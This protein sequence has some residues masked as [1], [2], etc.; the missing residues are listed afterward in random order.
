MS[1]WF[2]PHAEVIGYHLQC[3]FD[4]GV[5]ESNTATSHPLSGG[6]DAARAFDV[7]MRSLGYAAAHAH[8]GEAPNAFRVYEEG[9]CLNWR[10]TVAD[11]FGRVC[12]D[13][14]VV[15]MS[16]TNA[17]DVLAA[18]GLDW[19]GSIGA[20]E[21]RERV[22]LARGLN[23]Y[24]EA[25]AALAHTG[26]RGAAVIHVGREAGYV[27]E[28]LARLAEMAEFAAAKGVSISWS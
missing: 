5:Y 4:D 24:D 9:I 17:A 11:A 18:L 15:Q 21:M 26:A 16:N 12:E 6:C 28:K 19:Y 8:F 1:V 25:R 22:L 27:D 23:T 10:G 20:A 2:Q 3:A 13:V 7:M 14:P